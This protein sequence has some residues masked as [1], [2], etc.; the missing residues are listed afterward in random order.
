MIYIYIIY[1]VVSACLHPPQLVH[2]LL[3][4]EALSYY[5][6]RPQATSV[7]GLKLLVYEASKSTSATTPALPVPTL[8]PSPSSARS[9]V[10]SPTSG[11][12][13]VRDS[14]QYLYLC[15]TE[16]SKLLLY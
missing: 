5:C 4:Y 12:R 16:A 7:L 6:M 11:S 2:E 3:V 14:L 8:P 10:R 15:T 9:F 13:S 1:E